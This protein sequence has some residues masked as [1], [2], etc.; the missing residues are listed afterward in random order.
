MSLA[1]LLLTLEVALLRLKPDFWARNK[2][3]GIVT[4]IMV[5]CAGVAIIT[6]CGRW[7]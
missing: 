1:P 6:T 7:L 4:G 2:F 3:E 5:A